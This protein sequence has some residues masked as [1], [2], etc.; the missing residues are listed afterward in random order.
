MKISFIVSVHALDLLLT[1]L[2]S[3]ASAEIRPESSTDVSSFLKA[4]R[5]LRD[6][7]VS[8]ASRL[9]EESQDEESLGYAAVGQ[10]ALAR[11]GSSCQSDGDCSG[12]CTW[13][14]WIEGESSGSC[15]AKKCSFK[16]GD[17]YCMVCDGPNGCYYSCVS[18][19]Q[20]GFNGDDYYFGFRIGW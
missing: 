9:D 2:I 1:S 4:R 7:A 13:C 15:K 12:S 3:T 5:F 19:D 18:C 11:C 8:P 16:N 20:G 14:K 17:E 6:K 10:R